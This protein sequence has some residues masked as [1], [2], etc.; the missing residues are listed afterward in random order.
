MGNGD[1]LNKFKCPCFSPH[2]WAICFKL[3]QQVRELNFMCCVFVCRHAGFPDKERG[4]V[5]SRKM[6][7]CTVNGWM[8]GVWFKILAQICLQIPAE[9]DC[10]IEHD[11]CPGCMLHECV[12]AAC[13][14]FYALLAQCGCYSKHVCQ[15][16]SFPRMFFF[17]WCRVT[18]C[19]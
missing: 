8:G 14:W 19:C 4:C 6:S 11:K 16:F 13:I 15:E 18:T 17:F 7:S 10:V 12:C 1:R 5:V 3:K 2:T 9:G